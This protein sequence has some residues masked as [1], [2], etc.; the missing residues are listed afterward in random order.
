M[1]K[2]ALF[3]LIFVSFLSYAQL[4]REHWFGPMVDRLSSYVGAPNSDNQTIYMSTGE[5]TP[6]KVDVYFNNAVIATYTL[7]KNNPQNHTISSADRGQIIAT[8]GSTN[9]TTGLFQ[10]V[11]MGFYLK[12]EKPFLQV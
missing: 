6:F 1:K 11:A 2:I 4:D 5:T 10:P 3:L 7:S 8:P 12:G 9:P